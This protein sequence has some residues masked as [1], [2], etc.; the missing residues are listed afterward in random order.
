MKR[1]IT[2]V[3]TVLLSGS[4]FAAEFDTKKLDELYSLIEK[5]NAGMGSVSIFKDGK[6]VYQR[7][8]GYADIEK[9]IRAKNNTRYR[10]GSISKTFTAV[11][12]LQMVEAGKLSYSTKISVYFPSIPNASRIS[13]E[14]LLR[15]RSG[16]F[17]FTSLPDFGS[18]M[19]TPQ[20]R[21]ELLS[22]LSK[23]ET[24]FQPGEKTE[25][26]NT[27]YVLLSMILEKVSGA[28]YAELLQQRIVKPLK[29]RDTYYGGKI[30]E[31]KNAA[32]SYFKK[33]D[34]QKTPESD[35][36]IPLGA[37]GIVSTPT[38]L[39]QFFSALFNG[40]LVSKQSL[41]HMKTLVDGLGMGLIEFPYYEQKVLG[42]NGIIDGFQSNAGHFEDKNVTVSY[43]SN[44]TSMGVNDIL[45]GTLNLYF[46]KPYEMPI[47]SAAIVV[48]TETLQLYVGT[49]SSPTFPLK[50]VIR[51]EN[52]V[53]VGQATGQS[54][55]PLEAYAEHMFRFDQAAL[56]IAFEP[57]NSV[58][59]LKQGGGEFRLTRE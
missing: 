22:R 43:I 57:E 50:I 2:A 23:L 34:W 17:N 45:I 42:H 55:F 28:A 53:L 38:D 49:Y 14:H 12:L 5:N 56:K 35:M 10:I 31:E 27:N 11:M 16:L 9:K 20:S 40:K 8:I 33:G 25:Y 6:E 58:L 26:S 44:G 21:A 29:L 51:I 19:F 41:I 54:A 15:H 46:G 1:V 13:V 7:S 24:I 4:L 37:G 32:Y 30:A 48:P 59:I 52:G 39:N 18:W 36:S 3:T 47:F